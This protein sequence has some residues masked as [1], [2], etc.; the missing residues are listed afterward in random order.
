[1]TEAEAMCAKQIYAWKGYRNGN[2]KLDEIWMKL[3]SIYFQRKIDF[4]EEFSYK[5][6]YDE[7]Y[8]YE[9]LFI[10]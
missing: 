10:C 2:N 4:R 8:A 6:F 3:D 7:I 5:N 9:L 1:M